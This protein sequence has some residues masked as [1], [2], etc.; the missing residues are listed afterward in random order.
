[1]AVPCTSGE[2]AG[3]VESVL[4]GKQDSFLHYRATG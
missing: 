1:V 4:P 3:S 2:A